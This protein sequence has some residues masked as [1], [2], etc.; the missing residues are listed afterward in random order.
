VIAYDYICVHRFQDP[1]LSRALDTALRDIANASGNYD[2]LVE[3]DLIP[4]LLQILKM[5]SDLIVSELICFLV[6]KL[7]DAMIE[8]GKFR[9]VV[10]L[11]R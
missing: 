9:D 6:S 3:A 10:D 4:E 8:S 7:A 2:V 1:D 11:L 5:Q